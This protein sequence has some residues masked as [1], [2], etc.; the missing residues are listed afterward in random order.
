[1]IAGA[2]ACKYL[3]VCEGI[4]ESDFVPINRNCVFDDGSEIAVVKLLGVGGQATAG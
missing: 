3:R 1:M 4:S 2:F